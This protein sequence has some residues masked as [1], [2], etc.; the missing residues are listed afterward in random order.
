MSMCFDF[1]VDF[2]GF[3]SLFEFEMLAGILLCARQAV[4][5]AASKYPSYYNQ[6]SWLMNFPTDRALTK[7]HGYYSKL[8]HCQSILNLD[9]S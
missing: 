3:S 2:V 7:V 6:P 9:L 4:S 5:G 1:F 8:K